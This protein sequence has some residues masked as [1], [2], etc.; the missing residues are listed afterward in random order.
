MATDKNIT[1]KQFNG[2]D[3]DTLY[4]KTI[5]SQIPDVYSKTETLTA[6]TLSKY[7]LT[8]DKLPND[9]FQQIKTLIDNVQASADG[10][11]RIQT[12]S[13]VGTGTYGA[14]HPCSLTFDFVPKIVYIY[15]I[16]TAKDTYPSRTNPV[17]KGFSYLIDISKCP[18]DFIELN[19]KEGKI[20]FTYFWGGTDSPSINDWYVNALGR[21]KFTEHTLFWYN[22][23][24][25]WYDY[26]RSGNPTKFTYLDSSSNQLNISGQTYFW[27]AIN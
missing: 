4:P 18:S 2:T 16:Q 10:K 26:D 14:S 5:A 17:E 21:V 3:Y 11:A 19:W 6:D 23:I 8:F 12:G 1:M 27:V 15:S 20:V 13:Y 22:V 9:V 24:A 25:K 7:G